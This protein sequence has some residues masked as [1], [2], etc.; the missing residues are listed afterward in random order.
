MIIL[1]KK[2][3]NKQRD[4]RIFNIT[5]SKIWIK[6][7]YVINYLKKKWQLLKFFWIQINN[8]KDVIYAMAGVN[9]CIIWHIFCQDNKLEVD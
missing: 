1:Y 9:S 5:L 3:D 4:N 6:N 2:P 7:R 8:K